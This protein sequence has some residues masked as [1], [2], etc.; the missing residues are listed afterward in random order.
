[1]SANTKKLT[2]DDIVEIS[3]T[4]K[5]NDREMVILD[6]RGP[7]EFE[8]G[9]L[10]NAHN[11]PVQGLGLALQMPADEFKEKYHFELPAKDSKTGIAVHCMSGKRAEMAAKLL[12]DAQYT[13]NLFV[14]SP[15]WSELSGSS[16][17]A[18]QL[19]KP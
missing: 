6:V 1:M 15:G 9:H 13:D 8:G 16:A 7:G 11:V 3:K 17:A 19:V 18:A 12:G 10:K 2:L 14:Y 4:G 5:L